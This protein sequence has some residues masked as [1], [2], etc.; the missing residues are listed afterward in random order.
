M[1]QGP[2]MTRR[3]TRKFPT[4]SNEQ[5]LRTGT[6]EF[7]KNFPLQTERAA[8]PPLALA[9]LG[10]AARRAGAIDHVAAH[11]NQITRLRLFRGHGPASSEMSAFIGP[12]K[13]DTV[14][15]STSHRLVMRR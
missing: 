10:L 9:R 12:A 8:L 1:T 5:N 2:V 4:L 13:P 3:T 6:S 7:D 14:K 15:R 11:Q